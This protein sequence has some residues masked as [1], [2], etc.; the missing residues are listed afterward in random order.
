VNLFT[1]L[2]MAA[3]AMGDRIAISH[4][5]TDIDYA[6]LL[7]ASRRVAARV[8]ATAATRLA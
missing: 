3:D 8:R 6:G 5:D 1:L 4:G 2:E 7:A